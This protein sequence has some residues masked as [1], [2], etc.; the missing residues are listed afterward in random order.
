M[1]VVKYGRGVLGVASIRFTDVVYEGMTFLELLGQS[2]V[3]IV[4]D[5]LVDEMPSA[6]DMFED[7]LPDMPPLFE[8]AP[9]S[10]TD[11]VEPEAPGVGELAPEP[12][13]PMDE[14]D[15]D[16][17]AADLEYGGVHIEAA[18]LRSALTAG[19][20]VSSPA[21]NAATL[22]SSVNVEARLRD[23]PAEVRAD[24]LRALILSM[25][26]LAV[27]AS[28]PLV[29]ESLAIQQRTAVSTLGS[30]LDSERPVVNWADEVEA[31]EAASA[32]LVRGDEAAGGQV[33]AA[34]DD[35]GG[36]SESPQDF[37]KGTSPAGSIA[38]I[39]SVDDVPQPFH[40][41]TVTFAPPPPM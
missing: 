3:T 20:W 30:V 35:P 13:Q 39:H 9:M 37:G 1:P 27:H 26:R 22:L 29:N 15:W 14:T 7:F 40:T 18:V 4:K 17:V 5:D 28:S 32:A 31:E 36:P 8:E 38:G 23:M 34:R 24:Y 10:S 16:K 19:R 33:P 6:I 2:E 12:I 21:S 41:G 11:K 25:G